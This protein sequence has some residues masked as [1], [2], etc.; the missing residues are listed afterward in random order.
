MEPAGVGA[1]G[2]R[3]CLRLQLL[4]TEPR[5]TTALRIVAEHLEQM[6]G[7]S[8]APLP[9]RCKIPKAQVIQSCERIRRLNP[10]PLNGLGGEV[11]TQYIIPDFYVM[12]D[13]GQL[14][15]VMN[16]Y[17]LPKIKIDPAYYE[18]IRSKAL[19]RPTANT[20]RKTT[21]R[22]TKSSNSCPTGK[23]RCSGSTNIS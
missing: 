2:L 12:E 17:F 22:R 5:D 16:D 21:G 4:R 3:D 1:A 23:A 13:G 6:A 10:K 14:R 9:R 15:C 8:T 7:S 19:S 20:F 18:L 11:F